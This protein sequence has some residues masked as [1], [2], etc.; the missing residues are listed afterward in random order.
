MH[1]V[2]HL[3]TATTSA[4]NSLIPALQSPPPPLPP[5]IDRQAASKSTLQNWRVAIKANIAT[6]GSGT[7]SCAS[8]LLRDYTSPFPATVVSLMASHGADV[9]PQKANCDEFGMGSYA[10]HSTHGPVVNPLN[11]ERVAGG[12]SGGSAAAVAEGVVRVALGTDTG[13]S[14]RLP[15][16]YCGVVGF[17]PTYGRFSRY[18]V[19]S[20]A[21][22]LDTVGVL[23][24]S[25]DDIKTVY[26]VLNVADPKDPTSIAQLHEGSDCG[27]RIFL[28]EGDKPLAGIVVGVPSHV[29]SMLPESTLSRYSNALDVLE[30][31]GATIVSVDL[32]NHQYA[33][34]AYYTIASAEASSNLARFDGVRYGSTLTSDD[35]LAG[36]EQVRNMFG[37]NVKRRIMLG[38]FVLG[39]S[40]YASYFHQSQVVRRLIQESYNNVF[41]AVHPITPSE[42]TERVGDKI[43]KCDF[44]IT[45][46]AATVAPLLKDVQKGAVVDECADDV[47]TVPVSLAGLPA[48]VVPVGGAAGKE[49]ELPL[50]MQIIG[51]FGRDADLFGISRVLAKQ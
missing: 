25:V 27:Q 4:T 11:M 23:A 46:A 16:S 33:L 40:S 41:K 47:M 2:R 28:E 6:T 32:D 17:K 19:V 44:I 29:A 50:G 37:P 7:T 1:R 26:D 31:K 12:S 10:I 18:G 15:A 22:S 45:P 8:K 43:D 42:S 21:S 39:S 36:L 3:G 13:G 20:Y 35:G 9:L 38:T 51:Q 49:G 14:V 48:I 30:E 5:W 24:K 34:G